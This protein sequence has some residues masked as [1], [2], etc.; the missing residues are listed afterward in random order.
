VLWQIFSQDSCP[1]VYSLCWSMSFESLVTKDVWRVPI[2]FNLKININFLVCFKYF[3]Q[4]VQLNMTGL[5][6]CELR[7]QF[8]K[9]AGWVFG[10]SNTDDRYF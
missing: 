7:L 5:I 6:V 10:C 9:F 4:C 1:W 2:S 8:W 3:Y